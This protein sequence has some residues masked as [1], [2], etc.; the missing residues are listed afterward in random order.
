[1]VELLRALLRF[2]TTNPPGNEAECVEFLADTLRG[3]AVE[4]EVLSPAPGRANLVARLP[5]GDGERPRCCSTA[6]S[7][8]SRP[9]PG[10]GA[11]AVRRRGPRRRHLG[12]GRGRHEADG[13][14]ER[15]H[16]RA[17]GPP[18]GAAA[19]ATSSWPRWPTRRP[20]APPAA[21]GWSTTTPTRSGPATPSARSAGPPST[22]AAGP[23][24]RSRWP[25]R[26]RLA[27]GLGRRDHR[28]GSIP[29]ED[30]AV[31]RLSEFLARAGGGGCPCTPRRGA[32]AS[33][34]A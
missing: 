9:R 19:A 29:H 2:D 18:R 28:H 14:H 23:S 5:G 33:S 3:S 27:A 30:N 24:T 1:V 15:G 6:T 32:P 8:W 21:R 22:S 12:P 13:G 4:P 10:A 16:G 17:A 7:T 31:V 11:P 26:D 34:E 20:A 25:R